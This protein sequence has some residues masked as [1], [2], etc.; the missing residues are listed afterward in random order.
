M[1]LQPMQ[2]GMAL[3][4]ARVEKNLTQTE[5]SE[6]LNISLSYIKD[7][8]RSR[9]IPSY[10]M[11][12]KVVRYFNLSADAIIYPEKD[13]ADSA[14]HKLKR[15]LTLC[16]EQQLRVILSVTESLLSMEAI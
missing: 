12:E 1:S 3:R 7:L 6:I 11:F 8:E 13:S 5:L 16:S 9:S 2:F 14:Y 10:Q 15:L 4:N